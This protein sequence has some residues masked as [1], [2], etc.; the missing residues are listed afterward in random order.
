[1]NENFCFTFSKKFRSF[2]RKNSIIKISLPKNFLDS[3]SLFK[4]CCLFFAQNFDFLMFY[5]NNTNGQTKNA[6]GSE[7]NQTMTE[8]DDFLELS[9][10]P[11]RA[12]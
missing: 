4:F 7:R 2:Q 3:Q 10:R 5:N 1:M 11:L 8:L 6:T 9:L 12:F